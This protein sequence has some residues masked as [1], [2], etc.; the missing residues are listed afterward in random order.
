METIDLEPQLLPNREGV[1]F[2]LVRR[3]DVVRCVVTLDALQS[4]FWLPRNVDDARILKTFADGLTRIRAVAER[5]LL[6]K[7][8]PQLVLTGRDF[9]RPQRPAR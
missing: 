9:E 4:Y 8:V 3:N 1:A 7:P 5:K 2:T 6:A